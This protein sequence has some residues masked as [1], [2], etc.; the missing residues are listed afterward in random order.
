[1][2]TSWSRSV[3]PLGLFFP[4]D[5]DQ[6][7]PARVKSYLPPP[8]CTSSLHSCRSSSAWCRELGRRDA[9]F[10][11]A[12]TAQRRGEPEA[13]VSTA[14]AGVPLPAPSQ[15]HQSFPSLGAHSKAVAKG[16][17]HKLV[18]GAS[19][20]RTLEMSPR[21]KELL[22]QLSS[23]VLAGGKQRRGGKMGGNPRPASRRCSAGRPGHPLPAD[24]SQDRGSSGACGVD[25]IAR[26]CFAR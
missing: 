20:S 26:R 17:K 12:E 13:G 18:S 11:V 6:D 15:P 1:M 2:Q 16:L 22:V 7:Q 3:M 24:V 14:S 9:A 5:L 23:C 25:G 21:Q 4:P 10:G 19:V 8:A